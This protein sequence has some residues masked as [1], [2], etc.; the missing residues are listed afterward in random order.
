MGDHSKYYCSVVFYSNSKEEIKLYNFTKEEHFE[1]GIMA[2]KR[3]DKVKGS[4]LDLK[5]ITYIL[6]K[7]NK[8]VSLNP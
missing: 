8:H 3:K 7:C 2:V 1:R 6:M 5:C 4:N